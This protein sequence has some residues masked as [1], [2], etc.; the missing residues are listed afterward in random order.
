MKVSG[1]VRSGVPHVE[2]PDI[3][4]TGAY[5]VPWT[6]LANTLTMANSLEVG[7]IKVLLFAQ[8]RHAGFFLRC[9]AIE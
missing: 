9:L 2:V 8:G 1:F 3:N 6:S 5:G 4:H 7:P